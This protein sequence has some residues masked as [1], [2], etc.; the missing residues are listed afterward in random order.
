M[1]G[2]SLYTQYMHPQDSHSSLLFHDTFLMRG[3]AE[4]MNLIIADILKSDI[5][6][7]CVSPE[8]FDPAKKGR[9]VFI[10]NPDF[11]RG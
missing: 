2:Q 3:G 5:A 9:K 7:A 10:T 6:T 4:R 1:Q 8:S 11:Q